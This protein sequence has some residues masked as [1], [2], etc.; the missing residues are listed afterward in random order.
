MRAVNPIQV[1]I[2]PEQLR[3]LPP[4]SS[5]IVVLSSMG[6]VQLVDTATLSTPQFSMFQVALET[7]SACTSIDISPSN[8]CL[9]FGDTAN[10]LHLYSS[11]SEPILNPFARETEF[12]DPV[13]GYAP[14]DITDSLAIYSSIPRPNI[15]IDQSSY[16]SDYWPDRFSKT[17]YRGTPEI[18]EEILRNMKVVGTIG[19]SRNIPGK[20]KRN[21]TRYANVFSKSIASDKDGH[22]QVSKPSSGGTHSKT[23]QT[24]HQQIEIPTAYRKV[25]VKLSKL[26]TDDF[27]F[28]RY[29]RTG[30]CGLEASLPN[31]YHTNAMLQILYFTEKLRLLILSHTCSVE[32]C[33]CCELSFLFHSK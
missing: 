18:E 17:V 6:Q 9:A 3:F 5:R 31:S 12:A 10:S 7:G 29:N 22:S 19:Y 20:Y 27:D 2:M 8:A 14:I 32:N 23:E 15:P 1:M 28:D 24:A 33:I 21:Q 30:F 16:C 26:G 13:Q 11:N 25:V 4:L